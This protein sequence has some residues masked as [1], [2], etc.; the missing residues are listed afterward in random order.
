MRWRSPSHVEVIENFNAAEFHWHFAQG[1]QAL[2]IGLFLPGC[3]SILSGIE[4]SLQHTLL[5]ARGTA[6]KTGDLGTTL[7]NKLLRD[8][9]DVGIPVEILAFPNENDFELK[10]LSRTPMAEIVRVRHN[11]AH[12]NVVEY[13]ENIPGIGCT[14]TPELLRSL[15]RTLRNMS[16]RWS[17]ELGKFR[18]D[19]D[20]A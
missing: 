3:I 2:N 13:I 11:L 20:A 5:R 10:I 17:R 4:A 1:I 16:I 8:A 19:T 12:G 15:A 14:F 6:P 9:R 18:A 7:S